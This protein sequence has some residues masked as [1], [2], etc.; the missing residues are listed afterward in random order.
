[1]K[2]AGQTDAQHSKQA[3]DTFFKVQSQEQN[4]QSSFGSDFESAN[5]NYASTSKSASVLAENL[6]SSCT[7]VTAGR[8]KFKYDW[9]KELTWLSFDQNSG[10]ENCEVCASFPRI[11]D[12]NSKIV[13][14]FLGPLKLETFKKHDKSFQH[15]ICVRANNALL[16]PEAMPLAM[17]VKKMDEKAFDYLKTLFNVSYY[18][19]KNNKP[20]TDFSGLLELSE[21]LGVQLQDEY[22]NTTRCK[23]FISQTARVISSELISEL[24]NAKYVSLLLDG[25][26]DKGVEELILYV[27]F[28]RTTK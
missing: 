2:R 20:F 13:K 11:S 16:A 19:A 9:C 15:Q 28:I 7:S 23:D 17:C 27:R 12:Q 4:E 5:I 6:S 21:K 22:N 10:V 8:G 14:G 25:S 1:M 3:T 24:E 26:T 18:I